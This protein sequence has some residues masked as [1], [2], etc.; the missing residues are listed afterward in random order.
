MNYCISGGSG[1]VSIVVFGVVMAHSK[2]TM[3]AQ[4]VEEAIHLWEF[5]GYWAN[6]IIFILAGCVSLIF[7]HI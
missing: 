1:V 7:L 3:A 2:H 6:C 5:L 4:T